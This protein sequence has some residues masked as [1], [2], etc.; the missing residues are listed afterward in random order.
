MGS[1]LIF[2][3]SRELGK[4]PPLIYFWGLSCLLKCS[5]PSCLWLTGLLLEH[6]FGWEWEETHPQSWHNHHL[7]WNRRFN[8]QH[9]G[10]GKGGDS[11]RNDRTFGMGTE[12]SHLLGWKP[13]YN[14]PRAKG[15]GLHSRV[16]MVRAEQSQGPPRA[17]AFGS[18]SLL[19]CIFHLNVYSLGCDAL[20]LRKWELVSIKLISI[21]SFKWL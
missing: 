16:R 2:Q 9:C 17:H 19:N 1:N 18:C 13:T 21:L 10:G 14:T 5:C 15:N 8:T 12:T 6:V 3:I 20:K 11:L 4:T 7:T